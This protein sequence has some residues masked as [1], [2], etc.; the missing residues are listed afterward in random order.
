MG[1]YDWSMTD[2]KGKPKGTGMGTSSDFSA[3]WSPESES[4]K[5]ATKVNYVVVFETSQAYPQGSAKCVSSGAD[6][7]IS[8]LQLE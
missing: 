2:S 1:F 6:S 4:L 8:S 3:N 5:V 7:A